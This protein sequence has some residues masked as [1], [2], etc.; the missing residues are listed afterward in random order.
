MPRLA[1]KLATPGL[2]PGYFRDVQFAQCGVCAFVRFVEVSNF[3]TFFEKTIDISQILRY[4]VITEKE[5]SSPG[6]GG[7]ERTMTVKI[8]GVVFAEITTNRSLTIKEAM[9]VAGYD[10]D[11]PEDCENAYNN[12][13]EG[14][15]LDDC[16]NYCF[17]YDAVELCY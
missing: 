17:D 8:N 16:G 14:F 3:A 9:Y 6:R 13:V 11:N 1:T 7:K 12:D 15:Y 2:C 10:I 5:T 4:N